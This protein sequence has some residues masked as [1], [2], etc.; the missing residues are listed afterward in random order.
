MDLRHGWMTKKDEE[1]MKKCNRRMLRYMAG[2]KWQ[3]GVASEE[4]A[5]RWGLRDILEITRQGRLQWFEHV[6]RE[7]E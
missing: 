3:D 7:G 5:K 1:I 2:V 4:V 6:R